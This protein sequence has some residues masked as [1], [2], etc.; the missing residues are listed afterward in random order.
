VN[1]TKTVYKIAQETRNKLLS[2]P[3]V[4][5][6]VQML[7]EKSPIAIPDKQRITLP[8]SRPST[9]SASRVVE[10]RISSSRPPEPKTE[11]TNGETVPVTPNYVDDQK[12][13]QKVKE[14]IEPRDVP[15]HTK[16]TTNTTAAPEAVETDVPNN[17]KPVSPHLSV[18][19]SVPAQS[20]EVNDAVFY[21]RYP[22]LYHKFGKMVI[23]RSGNF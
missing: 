6:P 7:E 1:A 13:E 10:S 12:P 19:T 21:R 22:L 8:K 15:E 9:K 23:F 5:Q 2:V 18:K 14:K 3:V 17:S 20:G 11:L 16:I 4:H